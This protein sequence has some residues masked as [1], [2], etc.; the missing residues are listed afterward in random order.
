MTNITSFQHFLATEY[1][2]RKMAEDIT[3]KFAKMTLLFVAPVEK[4]QV[5]AEKFKQISQEDSEFYVDFTQDDSYIEV[6]RTVKMTTKKTSFW[7][8]I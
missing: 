3:S 6:T 4:L 1:S 8:K 2:F 7:T 5:Y